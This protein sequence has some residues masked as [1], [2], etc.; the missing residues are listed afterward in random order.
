MKMSSRA[1]QLAA[2]DT[3]SVGLHDDRIWEFK[4][5]LRSGLKRGYYPRIEGP[6]AAVMQAVGD[7]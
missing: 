7:L 6:T 1:F 5:K 4:P 2:K 3:Q